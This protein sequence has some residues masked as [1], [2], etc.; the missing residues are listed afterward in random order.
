M[1]RINFFDKVDL[2]FEKEGMYMSLLLS[3]VKMAGLSLKNRVVMPPMCMYEVQKEDGVV[4]P[5]HFAH[6]GSRAIGQVGLIIIEATAV[7]PEGRLT[8]QDLGLWNDAQAKEL[9]KLVDSLHFLGAKV[10]IQLN[11]GGRKAKDA[12]A[13]VAPSAIPFS[14]AYQKPV[15]MTIEQVK[16]TQKDFV[17]AAKRAIQAGVDMIEIHGAHGYLI[18]EF[19]SPL[20]N[21][22][23]DVY[24]G[25]LK[26]RY[27]FVK[28]IINEIR[29]FYQESLWIRLSLSDYVSEQNSLKQWQV[30]AQWLEADGIDCIDV[31]TGGLIDT[32]PNIAIH[33]GYQVPF[34]TTLKQV[35]TIPVVA[36][37]LLDNPGLCEFL[38]QTKQTDLVAVGRGLLR[39]A[40]WLADA[41]K[42]LG[43][44]SFKVY[45]Q[46]YFRGEK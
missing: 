28:E 32:K 29:Q 27:R 3:P 20:T 7:H 2:T 4:T 40:N 33:G 13:P 39:N 1:Q 25:S 46:S 34:A 35:V 26:N 24:G 37:G 45:N 8:S 18:N 21:R 30:I 23:Q 5:F 22:R 42:A 14:E 9:K 11:H 15:E 41:S 36:V 19:L 43:D 6:Y 44:T 38:L 17:L 10:G 16:Q 31:S 12:S